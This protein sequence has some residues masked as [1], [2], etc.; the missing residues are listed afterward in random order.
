MGFWETFIMSCLLSILSALK[1][2]PAQVPV[3]KTVLV[4]ILN[5]VC[6]LLGVQPPAVP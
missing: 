4:H 1:A 6:E 5:D 2:T 3:F